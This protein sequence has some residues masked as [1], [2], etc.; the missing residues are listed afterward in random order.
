MSSRESMRCGRVNA[1][2]RNHRRAAVGQLTGGIAQD[3][4]NLLLVITGNLELLEPHLANDRAPAAKV[5]IGRWRRA[6]VA[7]WLEL[8][9]LLLSQLSKPTPRL[10]ASTAIRFS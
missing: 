10:D 9:P 4:N 8:R 2:W 1:N 6:V 7:I 5:P 3:F